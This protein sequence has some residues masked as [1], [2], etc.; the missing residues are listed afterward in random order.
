[1]TQLST[2]CQDNT[3]LEN[4]PTHPPHR[5]RPAEPRRLFCSFPWR[6][7]YRGVNLQRYGMRQVNVKLEEFSEGGAWPP[8][9]DS[10]FWDTDGGQ[11]G[12]LDE[13]EAGEDGFPADGQE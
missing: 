12:A 7:G 10:W 4:T 6:R 8:G 3:P 11:G 9:D 1:M 2:T 5:R 13:E